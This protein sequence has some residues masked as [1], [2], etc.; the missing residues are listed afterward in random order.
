MV[1]FAVVGNFRNSIFFTIVV[2]PWKQ[3]EKCPEYER[4][5]SK[6]LSIFRKCVKAS[7]ILFHL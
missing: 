2:V 6:C 1:K 4:E 3:D 5:C 7:V